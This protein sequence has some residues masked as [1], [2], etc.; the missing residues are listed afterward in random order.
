MQMSRGW[1]S[2]AGVEVGVGSSRSGR[3]GLTV[4]GD[5]CVRHKDPHSNC[6]RPRELAKIMCDTSEIQ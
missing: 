4:R 3:R 5:K 1:E 6:Q 2:E